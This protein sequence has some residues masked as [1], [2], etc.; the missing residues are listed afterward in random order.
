[1]RSFR[2]LAL[3]WAVLVAVCAYGWGDGHNDVA[4]LCAAYMP[5]EPKAFLGEWNDQ[6]DLWCHYP[7]MTEGKGWGP[8]HFM[9]VADL[10]RDLGADAEDFITWGFRN[11]NWLHGHTGR[12]VTFSVLKKAFATNKPKLAAFCISVLSHAVSDQG[13]LNHPPI[14]QFTTYS[15]FKGVDYGWKNDGEFT[16][17]D[18]V[19]AQGVRQRLD[20]YRPQVL[21]KTFEEAAYE[22]VMDCYR[23]S[24][25]AA[26]AEVAVAFGTKAE[27]AAAMTRV[28][29][30]QMEAMTDLIHTAWVLRNEPFEITKTLLSGIYPREENR[31]RRGDPSTQAVYRGIF[32]AALNPANPKATVGIVCEPYG[33]FHVRALS[34]VGKILVA[35]AARTLRDNGYAVKGISFW[36][37]EKEGLPSP[38]AVPVILI[39]PGRCSGI[40][41]RQVE[42]LTRYRAAGGRLF[43]MSG[44]DPRNFTGL[45]DLL[46]RRADDD[47]PVSSKWG[48]LGVGDWA[49]MRVSMAP[50]MTRSGVGPFKFVRNPN[51]DGFCKPCCIWSLKDDASVKPL[52]RLD[53]GKKTFTIGG[54]AHGVC[55]MP[56]YLFLPFL[57]SSDRTVN[58]AD[59]RLDSFASKVL[60]DAMENLLVSEL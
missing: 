12:I 44:S 19:V 39:A 5:A 11:G 18:K 55:W 49:G 4:K 7:D 25:V 14:L 9:E 31:R 34:Y 50:T 32:D 22:M 16:L 37:V 60:L 20:A 51:F 24:E 3:C 41:T 59:M 28:V 42:T 13:A 1:M 54:I 17:T 43:V 58:W 35:A 15:K 10:R 29:A 46:E 26:E 38:E 30:V 48:F 45:K 53:N 2:F 27:H 47:V 23:Q 56:E 52:A 57:F 36:D 6:L 33:T 8:R 21:G 40:S